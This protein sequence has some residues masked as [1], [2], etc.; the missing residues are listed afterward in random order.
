MLILCAILGA[1]LQALPA[2]SMHRM[3]I[4]RH[5]GLRTPALDAKHTASLAA[6]LREPF[7]EAF[8]ASLSQCHDIETWLYESFAIQ[9]KTCQG[10]TVLLNGGSSFQDD[11]CLWGNM[12]PHKLMATLC[13]AKTLNVTVLVE[14]GRKGG[15]SAF[16]Y[17]QRIPQVVSIE[18]NTLSNVHNTLQAVSKNVVLLEGDGSTVIPDVVADLRSKNQRV[19]VIIDGPKGP[20]AVEVASRVINEVVFLGIDDAPVGSETRLAIERTFQKGDLF[21]SDDAR[22]QDIMIDKDTA[23]ARSIRSSAPKIKRLLE[24]ASVKGS[25]RDAIAFVRGSDL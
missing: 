4:N 10:P 2:A 23:W 25:R 19:A 17:S 11:F 7:S 21:Y 8:L 20:A 16:T 6:F 1:V 22:Y 9:W 13:L 12:I 14:S 15:M 24:S 18:M 3:N 5:L